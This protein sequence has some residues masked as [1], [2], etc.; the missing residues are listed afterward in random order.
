MGTQ[1]I[2]G[3][4][5]VPGYR[6]RVCCKDAQVHADRSGD[7]L[8]LGTGLMPDVAYR[9]AKGEA[10]TGTGGREAQLRKPLDLGLISDHAENFGVLPDVVANDRL[11]RASAR[12][13]HAML[14]GLRCKE[15]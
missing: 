8:T 10:V 1:G 14:D 12:N 5:A 11:L 4:P 3:K 9:F 15:F 6:S 7:V 13:R 2:A